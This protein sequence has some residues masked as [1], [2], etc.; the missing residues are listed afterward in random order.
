MSKYVVAIVTGVV[1]A[2]VVSFG[3]SAVYTAAGDGGSH[4]PLISG[5][6]VGAFTSYIMANLA[7]N[8]KVA[9][10]DEAAKAEALS[11]TPPPGKALIYLYREGFVGK[12]AGLNVSVDGKVVA[13]LKS[14]R[15][16][17]VAVSPGEHR[18]SAAFGGLAGPQNASA[19]TP[20]SLADGQ[21]AAFRYGVSMGLMQNTIAV[22]PMPDLEAVKAALARM[23]MT[24]PDVPEV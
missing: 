3:L 2:F 20:V 10:A 7:G 19:E 11:F 16:T 8:R 4:M 14:P 21:T 1:V 6:L 22:T 23:P 13:Q 15:F 9:T 5:I 24:V 12:A 18:L 17:C